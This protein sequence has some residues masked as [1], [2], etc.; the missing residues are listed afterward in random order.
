MDTQQSILFSTIHVHVTVNS[1]I[2]TET[3]AKEMQH[4]AP[5]VLIAM[6]YVTADNAC[7]TC[8]QQQ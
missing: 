5:F 1:V 3:L 7:D 8:H 4:C 2:N 6:L